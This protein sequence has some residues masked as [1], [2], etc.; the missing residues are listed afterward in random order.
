MKVIIN[1]VQDTDQ[2]TDP[3]LNHE[4]TTLLSRRDQVQRNL[5]QLLF[6]A[7]QESFRVVLQDL[8]EVPRIPVS[9][10]RFQWIAALPTAVL[11]LVVSLFLILELNA[12]RR[13]REA[14]A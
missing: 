8:A 2:P 11:F 9:D 14:S 5:A 6:E 13:E 1:K 10:K 7:Q 4:L 3:V 12:G